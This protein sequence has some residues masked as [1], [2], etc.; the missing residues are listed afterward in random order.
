MHNYIGKH[1]QKVIG[2][3]ARELVRSE[4]MGSSFQTWGVC[5]EDKKLNEREVGGYS[6][7]L[8]NGNGRVDIWLVMVSP[9]LSYVIMTQDVLYL[10]VS[11][12]HSETP[13]RLAWQRV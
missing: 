6:L 9:M 2:D 3:D 10:Q 5:V 12:R 4:H 11:T 8:T 1:G 7:P 13:C